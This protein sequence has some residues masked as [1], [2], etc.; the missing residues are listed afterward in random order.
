MAEVVCAVGVPHTPVFP[1]RAAAEPE[2]DLARRFAAVSGLLRAATPDVLVIFSGDHLNGFFLDHWPA[3]AVHAGSLRGPVDR[4]DGLRPGPIPVAAGLA[5]YVHRYLTTHGFE[6]SLTLDAQVDHGVVVPRHFLDTEGAVPVVVVHVN[7]VLSPLPSA[8]RCYALGRTVGE[9]VRAAGDGVRVGVVAS[10]SLSLEVGGPGLVDD[11]MWSVP[12]PSWASTVAGCLRDGSAADLVEL[13]SPAAIGEAGS[14]GGEV[15]CWLA[16]RGA[17][18]GLQRATMDHR[19]GEG[20]A[21]G[22]WH[23]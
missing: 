1:A 10:G 9:A 8:T 23:D 17:A 13:V 18:E 20:H 19:N 7:G 3:F 16:A 22:A 2:G 15:L 11:R 5:R 4:V 6:P 14:V 21:F 12:A